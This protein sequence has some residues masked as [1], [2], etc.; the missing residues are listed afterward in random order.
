LQNSIIF[1]NHQKTVKKFFKQNRQVKK[2]QT[3]QSNLLF[4][5]LISENAH[6]KPLLAT[7]PRGDFNLPR[8]SEAVDYVIP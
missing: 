6:I 2:Q 4:F 8:E 1:N 3:T 5:L 7:T